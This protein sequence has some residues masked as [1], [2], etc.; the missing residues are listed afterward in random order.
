MLHSLLLKRACTALDTG[1]AGC[2]CVICSHGIRCRRC[3]GIR[4]RS[5]WISALKG[6]GYVTG[7]D[8]V[9]P[10]H[11]RDRDQ[12]SQRHILG[13]RPMSE[14]RLAV[15]LRLQ[16]VPTTLC[17]MSLSS[18]QSV[19]SHRLPALTQVRYAIKQVVPVQRLLDSGHPSP[20]RRSGC[21]CAHGL[22]VRPRAGFTAGPEPC[23]SVPDRSAVQLPARRTYES[24]SSG[25]AVAGPPRRCSPTVP[26]GASV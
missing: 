21:G 12:R 16:T 24:R 23:C 17:P 2:Q 26:D 4:S 18:L 5:R 13:P 3:V 6:V 11:S 7:K 20:L 19:P 9:H 15:C 1:T 10:K 14:S 8:A 22:D 25:S